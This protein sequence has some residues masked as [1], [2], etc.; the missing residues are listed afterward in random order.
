MKTLSWLG[1][2]NLNIV[3]RCVPPL[4]FASEL[5]VLAVQMEIYVESQH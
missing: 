2:I 4:Q 3:N 5:S 1:M